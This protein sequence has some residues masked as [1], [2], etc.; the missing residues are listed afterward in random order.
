MPRHTTPRN[1]TPRR[2]IPRA[3]PRHCELVSGQKPIASTKTH[4]L[5][6]DAGNEYKDND[7]GKP[8]HA[9][10]NAMQHNAMQ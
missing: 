4:I 9:I 6:G 2:D 10:L 8:Q 5:N 3:M 1:A 7:D